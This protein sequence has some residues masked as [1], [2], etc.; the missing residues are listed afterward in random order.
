VGLSALRIGCCALL[1]DDG[2]FLKLECDGSRVR[3]SLT[4]SFLELEGLHV[5]VTGAAGGIGSAVV[6]EFLGRYKVIDGYN[7]HDRSPR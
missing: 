6:D 5:F 3:S 2:C 4:M 7:T 1:A